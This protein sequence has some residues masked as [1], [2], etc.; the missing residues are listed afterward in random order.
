[1]I[2]FAT[3]LF[4]LFCSET[5]GQTFSGT[6]L[7]QETKEPI[8][9]VH[10]S[11]INSSI[12]TITDSKGRFVLENISG[13]IVQLRISAIGYFT[14]EYTLDSSVPEVQIAGEIDSVA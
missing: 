8:P 12:G 3:L 10:L 13:K 11:L 2:R 6:I 9:D 7:D 1:M 14:T 4:I 5:F